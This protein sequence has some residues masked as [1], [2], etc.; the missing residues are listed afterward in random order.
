M[1][2]VSKRDGTLVP[3][4]KQKIINAINAAF[5]EIDGKLYEDD[6]A[7][8]IADDIEDYFKYQDSNGCSVEEI[9]DLVEDYLMRSERRDVA[10]AYIRYRYKK[11]VA[12]NYQHDFIDAIREKLAASDV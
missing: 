7:K 8:D 5:I 10:R 6:T 9:Q 12:R 11:E 1:I 4:D 3:F 2:L